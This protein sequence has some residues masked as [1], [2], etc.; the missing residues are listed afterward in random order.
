M[1]GNALQYIK[2]EY[3]GG[4]LDGDKRRST[5][6]AEYY[7]SNVDISTVHRYS[8]HDGAMRYTGTLDRDE[9]PRENPPRIMRIGVE[10]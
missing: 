3:V 5:A 1:T 2:A 9:V 4:P 8:Q 6:F 7:G 10:R